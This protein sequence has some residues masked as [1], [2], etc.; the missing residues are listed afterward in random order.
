MVERSMAKDSSRRQQSAEEMAQALRAVV[1]GLA[2]PAQA[3]QRDLAPAPRPATEAREEPTPG[4]GGRKARRFIYGAAFVAVV[5]AAV[6]GAFL[7]ASRGSLDQDGSE[8]PVVGSNEVGPATVSLPAAEPVAAG[9]DRA[10]GADVIG[11]ATPTRTLN[12]TPSPAQSLTAGG[13][14]S[15]VLFQDKFE[16]GVLQADWR[17]QPGAS[18]PRGAAWETWFT[19]TASTSL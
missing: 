5:A 7:L 13:T 4:A 2:K 18:A 1:P 8:E 12:P 11:G 19:R 6:L 10:N 9:Q 3:K 14:A 17:I 16:S 15:N